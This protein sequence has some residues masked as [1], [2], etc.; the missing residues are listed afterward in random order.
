MH[1]I[2]GKKNLHKKT[3]KKN[4][5]WNMITTKKNLN[6]KNKNKKKMWKNE[7]KLT[8]QKNVI[9]YQQEK[10]QTPTYKIRKKGVQVLI[11]QRGTHQQHHCK[12]KQ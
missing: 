10:L 7:K 9:N 3:Q 6:K 2:S 4:Q 1:K 8:P 12:K 11:T 5:T